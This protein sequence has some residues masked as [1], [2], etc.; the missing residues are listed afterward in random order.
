MI[1]AYNCA[2]FLP[3]TLRSVLAQDPGENVMQIQVVDDASTDTDVKSLVEEIGKG[4]I[5]YFRQP[6]N[7]G[8][9]K[10][11]ETCINLAR[12]HIIHLLHGDDCVKPGY[13]EKMTS[14]FEQHPQIGAAFSA[15]HFIDDKGKVIWINEPETDEEGILENWLLKIAKKQRVQYCSIAVKRSV[16]EH[17]G[18]YYGVHYGEDWEMWT[19]I[20]AHYPV[21]YSPLVLAEYR[22]HPLSISSTSF[23]TAKNIRDIR[24]V[25][26][27]IEKLVPEKN[28][29][30]VR[31]AA[32]KSYAQY[33]MY[34][35]E[36]LWRNTRNR[37]ITHLQVKEALKL[38]AGVSMFFK[39][40]KI[41]A[42][43]VIG[44]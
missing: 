1:P 25:I 3:E 21:A 6:Q 7:V 18:G 29:M 27:A 19:R 39:A 8:S 10:N 44:R 40:A 20:A 16:Y 12:G 17:L 43:M 37:K 9:L 33:A 28:K 36:A 4:R 11:F 23:K 31:K 42:R 15:Y 30:E 38:Y 32:S 34:I 13:Y 14:L 24:W 35:A 22:M 2:H 26:N 5:E 41:Y